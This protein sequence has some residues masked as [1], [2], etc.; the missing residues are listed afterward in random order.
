MNK[1]ITT[2]F[3]DQRFRVFFKPDPMPPKEWEV[4]MRFWVTSVNRKTGEVQF[5]INLSHKQ[6]PE[7]E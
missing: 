5:S 6:L 2:L 4:G 7:E 3:E 1:P